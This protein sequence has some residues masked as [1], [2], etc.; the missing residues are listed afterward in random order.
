MKV[1]RH[2]FL[3][4]SFFAC[5]AAFCNSDSKNIE[6]KLKNDLLCHYDVEDRPRQLDLSVELNYGVRGFTYEESTSRISVEARILHRWDD[7]RL[8]W[9]ENDYAGI[10]MFHISSDS[11]WI[12]RL[13]IN[14][15]FHHY[16][17]GDCHPTECLVKSSGQI[18]CW[19]PCT[20]ELD[21]IADYEKWPFDKHVCRASFKTFYL[22]ENVTFDSNE[23][24][25][26][27]VMN[28]NNEWKL[29]SMT[30]LIDTKN[31]YA[32]HFFI[33]IERY[34]G[35]IYKHVII[36][37]YC[38]IAFT[39]AILWIKPESFWRLIL[40]GFNIYLHFSLMDRVWWQFPS[41]GASKSVPKILKSM[42]FMLILSTIILIESIIV[43]AVSIRCSVPPLWTQKIVNIT[44]SNS[45]VK[46][47][48]LSPTDLRENAKSDENL[49]TEEASKK[50]DV[51]KSFNRII[52]RILFLLLCIIYMFYKIV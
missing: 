43:K 27:V 2:L 8:R 25:G 16:G 21:C 4:I 42:T 10:K 20:Q 15:S 44:D 50:R 5:C 6:V 41:N 3:F 40:C 24:G 37:I 18:G 45:I 12:P 36:P 29:T 51:M 33:T 46:Y 19:I 48:I 7:L 35:M 31:K 14:N 28:T 30:G 49:A 11:I 1:L 32:V 26:Q 13:F 39:L 47:V 22:Y 38:L 9:E 17:L 34:T 23:I 52:D